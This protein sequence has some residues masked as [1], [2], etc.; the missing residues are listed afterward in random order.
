MN[1]KYPKERY[2][3]SRAR[4]KKRETQY[5]RIYRHLDYFLEKAIDDNDALMTIEQIREKLFEE[6]GYHLNVGTL[7]NYLKKCQEEFGLAPLEEIYRINP[8]YFDNVKVK[9]PRINRPRK[10][11]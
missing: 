10:K 2:A 9:A 6:T 7:K 11:K 4:W 3:E 1:K 5:G 8:E